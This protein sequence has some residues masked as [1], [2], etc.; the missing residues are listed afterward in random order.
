MEIICMRTKKTILVVDDSSANLQ[1]CRGLLSGRYDVRLAKSGKMAMAA[2]EKIEPDV[3]LLDIEMPD[4][5]GF[6]VLSEISANEKLKSI[7][8]IFV[9]SHASENLVLKAVGQG[10]FGYI[11][12]PFIPEVLFEKIKKAIE[13]N[14]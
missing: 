2:L 3:I 4:M 6:E 12:K 10:A 11:V 5:S 7:P 13:I 8:V 1:L 9:T 14:H